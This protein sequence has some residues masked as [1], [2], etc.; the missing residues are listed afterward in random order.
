MKNA[1]WLWVIPMLA[2]PGAAIS[3]P[4]GS[5]EEAGVTPVTGDLVPWRPLGANAGNFDNVWIIALGNGDFAAFKRAS[6]VEQPGVIGGS[7]FFLIG[8]DGEAKNPRSPI[9]G[10]YNSDGEPTPLA[11]FGATGAAWGAFTLGAHA[12][13]W[14]EGFVVHNQG[15]GAELFG[16]EHADQV[17]N[18]AFTMIQLFDNAGNPLGSSINAFGALTGEPGSYRDIGALYLSNGDI[19]A[20]GENRQQTDDVLD[21]AL[22]NAGEVAMAVILGPDGS[23]KHGPF[24]PHVDEEGLYLGGS[25][26]VVYQNMAAFEGGFVID[27]GAG[28]RWYNNDGTPRTPAQPDHA[29]LEG[30]EIDADIVFFPIGSNSGGR[31][32]G[33]ALAGNGSGLVVKSVPLSASG[34]SIG[35]LIYYNTDGS[36]SHW[37][38]FDDTDLNE[39]PGRVDR[40]FCDMDS[41]GNVFVVWEDQRFGGDM[42]EGHTQVF[43]RFFDR[44]G[45]PHGPSFP[46]FENWRSEAAFLD[47][48][49]GIGSTPMGDHQQPRCALGDGAAA[50]IS[51]SNIV[52]GVPDVVKQLSN[53]FGLIMTEATVR[54]FENPY[55]EESS[56]GDWS[57]Y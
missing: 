57:V 8:P 36:V 37:T 15:E 16:L 33:M 25:S 22:A 49:G 34:E 39:E 6:D 23:A 10:S 48:G 30:E 4:A 50:V 38:R 9:R 44:D 24:I 5:P 35:L 26:S 41:S 17:G 45:E 51:A 27:Y 2:L 47:Y 52:P 46:V 54:V 12:N 42:D 53:A 1:V 43:G 3:Q 31:G 14:G 55:A 28:I 20:L 40:T 32:D 7:E 21:A 56:I 19:V 11:D 18:E 29:E 13:Q